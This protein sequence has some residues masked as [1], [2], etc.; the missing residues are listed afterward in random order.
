MDTP[1]ECVC[2]VLIYK[3]FSFIRILFFFFLIFAG[4]NFS[5]LLDLDFDVLCLEVY[6]FDV[7][8]WYSRCSCCLGC[9]YPIGSAGYVLA[10]V[11]FQSSFLRLFLGGRA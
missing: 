8:W 9:L 10:T 11:G 3:I 1:L 5:V 2:V 7:G 6:S 4:N